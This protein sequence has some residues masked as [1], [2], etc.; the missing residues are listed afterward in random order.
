MIKKRPKDKEQFKKII[1]KLCKH[2]PI[3]QITLLFNTNTKNNYKRDYWQNLQSMTV[4]QI[5][6]K[7]HITDHP[8]LIT[9]EH[10]YIVPP[11]FNKYIQASQY[12]M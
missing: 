5:K 10:E 11:D 4:K 9:I 1:L 8:N 3:K 12:I 6:D 7:M 2:S